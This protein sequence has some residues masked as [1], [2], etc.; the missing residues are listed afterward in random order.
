MKGKE[1]GEE[2][3]KNS[4]FFISPAI[5]KKFVLLRYPHPPKNTTKIPKKKTLITRRVECEKK[6]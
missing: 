1:E 6:N 5:L 2:E 3:E 4:A